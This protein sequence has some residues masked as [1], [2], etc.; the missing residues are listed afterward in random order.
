MADENGFL[1]FSI[2]LSAPSMCCS[3]E[4]YS[5]QKMASAEKGEIPLDIP[6]PRLF[7][8]CGQSSYVKA[9]NLDFVHMNLNLQYFAPRWSLLEGGS[10]GGQY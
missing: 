6:V 10:L 5:A 2:P 9:D 7:L 1:F 4:L 8:G 3:T